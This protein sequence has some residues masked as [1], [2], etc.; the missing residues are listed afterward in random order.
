MAIIP[1][2]RLFNWHDVENLGD[3]KRLKMV[4]DNLPDE[5]LVQ[6]L[7][8]ERGSRGRNDYPVRAVWNSIIAGIVFQHLGIEHLR[9]ELKRNAQLRY[10]CGLSGTPSSAAYTRF[11]RKLYSKNTYLEKIFIELVAKVEEQIE[12]FGTVLAIDGKPIQS[13][14]KGKSKS[15]AKDGRRDFDANWGKHEYKG[16]NKDG[17]TWIKTETW[18]GYK[19][20]LIVD[21]KYELPVDFKVTK[22]SEAELPQAL[23]LLK[24]VK[25]NHPNLLK[26]TD[27]LLGDRG[28][29]ATELIRESWDK[30]GIKPIIDIRNMWKDGEKTRLLKGYQNVGYN[31]RGTVFC[32]CPKTSKEKEMVYGGFEKD[33]E[34]LKYRCPAIHYGISCCGK[35]IC[36]VK[37]GIR[38]PLETD[39]R[40]FTPVARSSY[41]WEAEYNK[42]TAIERVNSRI[43]SLYGFENHFIRGLSKMNARCG[44]ALC[45]M[46]SMALGRIKTKNGSMRSLVQPA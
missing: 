30:Y 3:L 36:P 29:D 41:K 33:R 2:L 38:I 27:Y 42:R 9:R 22:A 7:E 45:V 1:Q 8:E 12:D 20:H 21:A 25:K 32:Y 14:A 16:V 13:F 5:E 24:S 17:S 39:R 28:Y 31:Y 4:L 23:K 6:V 19:L 43:D 11:F 35:D 44:L 26:R 15:S 34:T 37:S 40:L 10:V 18:F 46:L